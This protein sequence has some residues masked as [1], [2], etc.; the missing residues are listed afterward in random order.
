MD[1]ALSVEGDPG[2]QR[3]KQSAL[4]RWER[5][6]KWMGWGELGVDLEVYRCGDSGGDAGDDR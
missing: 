6:S 1:A 5:R 4:V 3:G 2:S